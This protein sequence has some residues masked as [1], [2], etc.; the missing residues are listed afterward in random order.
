[1]RKLILLLLICGHL[2]AQQADTTKMQYV[3]A[4]VTKNDDGSVNVVALF[5][6]YGYTYWRTVSFG[7]GSVLS[8][9][10]TGM[11]NYGLMLQKQRND[12]IT[13][14][15]LYNDLLNL[16]DTVTIR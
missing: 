14:I 6:I 11:T 5:N 1:M 12:S 7:S 4:G 15:T 16:K 10:Q 2:Q 13:G 8:D 9:I 3:I